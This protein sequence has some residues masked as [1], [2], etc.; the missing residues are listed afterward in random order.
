ML[1]IETDEFFEALQKGDK[2]KIYHLLA[3]NPELANCKAKNGVS[4][5]L[6]AFYYGHSD[7]AGAIAEKKMDLDIFEAGVLGKLGR[8]KNL[9]AGD[10]SLVNS[11]SPDGFTALA[12]AAYLGQKEV[13]E[14]LIANGADVNAIAKNPT[15]FTALTGATANNHT[16]I[17]KTLVNHGANVNHRYEDGVS[18]LMEASLN[19]NAE[20]VRFLLEE[21]AE[22]NAKMKDGKSPLSF[23]KE[24]NHFAVVDILKKHGAI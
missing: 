8:V 16:E 18:P 22:P 14:Y 3:T 20:L 1:S 24:K 9:V 5:I 23:A 2:T 4:A 10:R 11:Y 19:G 12:L 21:G 7:I 15:G 17:A 6:Q 13:T